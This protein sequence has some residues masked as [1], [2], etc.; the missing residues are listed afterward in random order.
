MKN[1]SL[2]KAVALNYVPSKDEAPQIIAK[3]SGYV[4]EKIIEQGKKHDVKIHEDQSL[5][6]LL[7]QLE[8]NQQIPSELYPII[9]EIFAMVY[10]AERIAG[11]KKDA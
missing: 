11:I 10:Q 3:G 7:Y 9:A 1:N 8:L 6:Q 4:A 5:I 2:K